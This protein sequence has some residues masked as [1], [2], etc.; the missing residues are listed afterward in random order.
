MSISGA[1]FNALTGL[2][3]TSRGIELVSSNVA[4]A[5][6]D[7]YARREL[8]L[9]SQTLGSHGTGVRV[10]GVQ[11][12]VDQGIVSDLRLADA[13]VA[14]GDERMNFQS[15]IGGMLGTPGEAGSLSGR[16]AA[17]QAALV[18]ASNRPDSTARLGA[19]VAAAGEIAARLNTVSDTIQAARIETD[20]EIGRVVAKLND[21]LGKV[22]DLNVEICKLDGAGRDFS[23]LADQRQ[24]LIGEISAVVPVREL[25]RDNGM[26]ALLTPGGAL[27]L[28]G[29]PAEIGFAPVGFITADMTLQSGALSGLT[30]NG[31]PSD[32]AGGNGML[33]GG[34]LGALFDIRDGLAPAAQG[35]VDALARD[36][37]D[38]FADPALDPTIGAS[39]PGLFTDSGALLQPLDEVGLAGRLKINAQVDPAQGGALWRLRAGI[40]ALA[41][42]DSADG[43]LIA[44]LADRLEDGRVPASGPFGGPARGAGALAGEAAA[45]WS[46][47]TQSLEK[48]LTYAVSRADTLRSLH[49]Q[50]GVDTDHEMQ[51]LLT[52]EQ[53]YAANA[54]VVSTVDDLMQI[55]LGL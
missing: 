11:R 26:V 18:E 19:A 6:T 20:D 24:K 38:R 40:H 36:L 7:G 23:T 1:L 21:D 32:I 10:A 51:Q 44:A 30:V 37:H 8:L 54:R 2:T 45:L 31:R 35:I 3:A 49:L 47:R 5:R 29:Q 9:E 50:D 22:R 55:L 33:G 42:N 25:P 34:R 16:I 41:P 12:M 13:A 39:Q 4:N 48:G 15:R 28:D 14:A 52:L 46:G 53:A 43:T 27:V 17:L